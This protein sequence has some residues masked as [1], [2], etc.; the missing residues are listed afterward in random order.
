M[1]CLF[2]LPCLHTRL[3]PKRSEEN[4]K[5]MTTTPVI[6]SKREKKKVLQQRHNLTHGNKKKCMNS[7]QLQLR[8]KCR[9]GTLESEDSLTFDSLLRLKECIFSHL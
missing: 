9:S 7:I 4:E 1:L 2:L 6:S 3:L 8:H 5:V